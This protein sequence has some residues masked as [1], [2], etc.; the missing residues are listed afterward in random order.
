MEVIRM[1][2]RSTV[3]DDSAVASPQT[4]GIALLALVVS[5]L[6][7]ACGEQERQGAGQIKE[8]AAGA[9]ETESAGPAQGVTVADITD[10]PDEFYG[11]RV[12]VSGIVTERVG[13]NAFAIGGDELFGGEQVVVAGVQSLDKLVPTF[14]KII[15]VSPKRPAMKPKITCRFLR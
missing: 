15:W 9:E 7:A 1:L 4:F 6:V 13:P 12:T 2:L 3:K 8:K 11:E 14:M 5:L 10:D